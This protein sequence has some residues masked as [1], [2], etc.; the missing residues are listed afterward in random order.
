[1][2]NQNQNQVNYGMNMQHNDMNYPNNNNF[3]GGNDMRNLQNN[4]NQ[5]NI[6]NNNQQSNMNTFNI[7]INSF[8]TSR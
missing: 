2:N 3:Y 4:F 8:Y 6:G 7:L 5:L 1:M